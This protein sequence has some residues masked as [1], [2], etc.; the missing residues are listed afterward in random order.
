M[1]E[2][3]MNDLKLLLHNNFMIT[4]DV[5]G[6]KPNCSLLSPKIGLLPR[7]LMKLISLIEK[8]YNIRIEENEIV[9]NRLDYLENLVDVLEQQL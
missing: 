8:K 5:L 3:L 7:D 2:Q 6:D 1:K 9:N 4:L